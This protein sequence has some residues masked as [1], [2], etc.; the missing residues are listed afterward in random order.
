MY[1]LDYFTSEVLQFLFELIKVA[2][3]V[4]GHEWKYVSVVVHVMRLFDA[5]YVT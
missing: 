4:S 3:D 2:E 1:L 5:F